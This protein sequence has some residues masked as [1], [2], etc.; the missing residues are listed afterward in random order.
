MRG[1]ER[2]EHRVDVVF[3]AGT[4]AQATPELIVPDAGACVELRA[5]SWWLDEDGPSRRAA[6]L[7]QDQRRIR[8]E[9]SGEIPK[10]RALPERREVLDRLTGAGHDDHA[11]VDVREQRVTS[12]D[13]VGLR[14]RRRRG[15]EHRPVGGL[16]GGGRGGCGG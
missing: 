2:V 12:C 4:E 11:A 6:P 5:G 3:G 8:L 16:L 14:E 10:R 7:D 13:V 9:E 1:D 15:S